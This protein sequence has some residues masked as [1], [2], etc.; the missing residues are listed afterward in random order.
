VVTRQLR[1][2]CP[3]CGSLEV[4]YSCSPS[5]C[6]NH[7]CSNC[8]T[9][10]EPVTKLAGGR[11]TG[12]IPPDPL[13]DAADPAVACA[14]CESTAVYVTGAEALVCA[15]CGSLLEL[16]LTEVTPDTP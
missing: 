13:P 14:R 2:P 10:F 11:L 16:E 7:V 15:A 4:Y 1:I 6:F 12:I 8:R 5:C 3:E 9:T